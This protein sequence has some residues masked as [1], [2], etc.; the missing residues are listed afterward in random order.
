ML[1]NI[2]EESIFYL[3]KSI[4]YLNDLYLLITIDNSDYLKVLD[5]FENNFNSF[6]NKISEHIDLFRIIF[7][8]EINN[9][10][11]L[12][13]FEYIF[14]NK[15]KVLGI[16][17]FSSKEDI[18]IFL[19]EF[20]NNLSNFLN[21]LS[22]VFTLFP[23]NE[24]KSWELVVLDSFFNKMDLN[25][26]S[27]MKLLLNELKDYYEVFLKIR[28]DLLGQDLQE[29]IL[30]IISFIKD[31][32]DSLEDR[33]VLS[34][35]N[36]YIKQ[37][38]E[39]DEYIQEI[40]SKAS[41]YE[42]YIVSKDIALTRIPFANIWFEFILYSYWIYENYV[43]INS[44]KN[45]YEYKVRNSFDKAFEWYQVYINRIFNKQALKN[46]SYENI[47]NKIN[48]IKDFINSLYLQIVNN[49]PNKVEISSDWANLFYDILNS[50][51]KLENEIHIRFDSKELKGAGVFENLYD[52]V[53]RVYSEDLS[54]SA[55]Y[56]FYIYFNDVITDLQKNEH[57]LLTPYDKIILDNI[58]LFNE[59]L[60]I[61]NNYLSD[62]ENKDLLVDL[63]LYF[64]NKIKNILL[65]ILQD[66]KE[67]EELFVVKK[68]I[69]VKCG[70]ENEYYNE[71]CVKC[72]SKLIK[73]PIETKSNLKL[74]F[75]KF[76]ENYLNNTDYSKFLYAF[77]NLINNSFINFES[78]YK[79][80]ENLPKEGEIIGLLSKIEN[81]LVV[82]A[83]I[84]NN[85]SL[86]NDITDES[87]KQEL[88]ETMENNIIELEKIL[89]D[90]N[91]YISSF[92]AN[93][94]S[95]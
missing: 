28:G 30:K 82:L 88:L 67:V 51:N 6:F 50:M 53:Y 23:N 72:N 42:Y 38:K 27:Y 61:V 63:W 92:Q 29:N 20:L 40:D 14:Q 87:E 11:V 52:I 1:K 36:D 76:R 33:S 54:I 16:S 66:Y 71:Y 83:D 48:K 49:Y 94:R 91:D 55:I 73:P 62:Y 2:L 95:I 13:I 8:K 19:N 5:K 58:D 77:I 39:I 9:E 43:F 31:V 89:N 93:V 75:D 90:F 86:F 64:E 59:F 12:S 81:I 32:V 46:E 65:N 47:K 69:C 60:N 79:N 45:L 56:N 34:K 68:I 15:E 57:N 25:Y 4:I 85:I 37:L 21:Y 84:R 44:F 80:L 22:S 17:D 26:S 18:L 70:F 3:N 41:D 7:F 24:L 10:E 35:A 78:I 74:I